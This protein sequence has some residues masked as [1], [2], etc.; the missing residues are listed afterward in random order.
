[1]Y[2]LEVV[3]QLLVYFVFFEDIRTPAG[4]K[5]KEKENNKK[6][7]FFSVVFESC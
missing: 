4:I 1:M 7:Y 6:K 3:N 2:V 5:Q